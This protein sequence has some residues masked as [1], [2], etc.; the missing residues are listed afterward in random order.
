[1]EASFE[2]FIR[3]RTEISTHAGKVALP[4]G[5]YIVSISHDD[6][7]N[8]DGARLAR[9]D[10]PDLPTIR[11]TQAQYELLNETPVFERR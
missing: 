2:A 4:I 8:P 11:L 3:K 6:L 9:V 10:A 7:G 5:H 1:M